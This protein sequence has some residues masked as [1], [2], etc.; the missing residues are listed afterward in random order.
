[1]RAAPSAAVLDWLDRQAAHTLFITSTSV[2]ELVCGIHLLPI[3]RRRSLL[4]NALTALLD[5]LFGE[6]ILGFDKAA[7]LAYGPLV[8]RARSAGR[9]IAIADAQIAAVAS[10]YG[11]SVAT[12]DSSAFKA[13]GSRVIDPWLNA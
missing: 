13:A 3:G 9:Q 10:V 1:M 7:A 8:A 12:R 6:R 11:F 5:E 4:A 2:G